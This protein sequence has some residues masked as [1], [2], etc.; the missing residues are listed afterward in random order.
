ML[1]LI[2]ESS[3]VIRM[4]I[5][6]TCWFVTMGKIASAAVCAL[7]VGCSGSAPAPS[8]TVG[9]AGTTGALVDGGGAAAACVK[10]GG[11]CSGDPDACCNGSTCV[12][13]TADP[14]RSVCATT[15]LNNSQCNSGCCDVLV[16]GSS[17]VCAP[18]SYCAPACGAPGTSCANSVN[19][20]CADAI[21]V[22]TKTDPGTCSAK[23][24]SSAQCKSGCCA[25]LSNTT[26]YVCSP[27]SFCP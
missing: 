11:G 9:D 24:T 8:P 6:H 15:C 4:L 16:S 22:S 21:C 25:P 20:C 13:D 1:I 3:L 26:D 12:F 19:S 23:C 5:Q 14:S 7:L 27:A 17:A 10:P 2:V 18:A